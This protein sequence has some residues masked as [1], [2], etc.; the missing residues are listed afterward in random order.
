MLTDRKLLSWH[1]FFFVCHPALDTPTLILGYTLN[2]VSEPVVVGFLTTFLV[3]LVELIE[4]GWSPAT[5]LTY[6][7]SSPFCKCSGWCY[8]F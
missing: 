4:N 2:Y 6:R 5:D 7:H 1:I 8:S 3:E